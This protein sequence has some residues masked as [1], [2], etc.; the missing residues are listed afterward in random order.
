M[1]QLLLFEMWPLMCVNTDGGGG[2]EKLCMCVTKNNA[3]L[4][5][6]NY[7]YSTVPH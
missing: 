2:T 1:V 4:E 3:G 5:C 7:I 6:A